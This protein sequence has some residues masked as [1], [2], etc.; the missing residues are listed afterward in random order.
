MKYDIPNSRLD[1]FDGYMKEID[2]KLGA[3]L[4]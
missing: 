3:I 2:D 1:M 4:P